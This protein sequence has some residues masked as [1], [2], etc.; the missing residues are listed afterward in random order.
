MGG[1]AGGNFGS[2]DLGG[3]L[4]MGSSSLFSGPGAVAGRGG[5]GYLGPGLHGNQS[6]MNGGATAAGQSVGDGGSTTAG[7]KHGG[8][9]RERRAGAEWDEAVLGEGEDGEPLS[10]RNREYRR[11]M[12][13]MD[14][15]HKVRGLVGLV[16]SGMGEFRPVGGYTTPTALP[17][18]SRWQR[19]MEGLMLLLYRIPATGSGEATGVRD[20]EA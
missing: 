13:E 5:V 8:A 16:A 2:A 12:I 14:A 4:N 1:P 9:T 7:Q 17:S 11:K 15:E 3:D 20:A 19:C 10:P 6:G 18:G